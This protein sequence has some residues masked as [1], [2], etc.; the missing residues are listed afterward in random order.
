[1][2]P[3]AD[4]SPTGF[5]PSHTHDASQGAQLEPVL[6]TRAF[7]LLV[8]ELALTSS[9]AYV[10]LAAGAALLSPALGLG[11][12]RS[13]AVGFS[14]VLFGL[15][16]VLGAES[17]G[18]SSV[19]GFT[20]P[21][22]VRHE[23][24]WAARGGPR[25][26]ARRQPHVAPANGAPVPLAHSTPASPQYVCWAELFLVQF[27]MPRASFTGHLAGILAGLAHVYL[28]KR[29]LLAAPGRA[30]GWWQAGARAHGSGRWGDGSTHFP[31]MP[32]VSAECV[33][34]A[35]EGV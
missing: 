35:G 19:A 29:R 27:V 18:W 2:D 13:C 21:S 31:E 11:L 20:L 6:G 9:L 15:K 12:M 14:G 10:G 33:W 26:A 25:A 4:P 28:V 3:K 1:M 22:K 7:L 30:R 16:V 17:A 23:Q 32:E 5:S 34:A 8:A 24:G